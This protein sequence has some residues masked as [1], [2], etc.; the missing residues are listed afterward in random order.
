MSVIEEI[1]DLIKESK[2][3]RIINTKDIS[4]T[5]HTFGDIYFERMVLFSVLCQSYPDDSFITKKH[6]NNEEDPMFEGDFMAGI[7]TPNGVVTFHFKLEYLKYFDGVKEIEEGPKWDKVKPTES[8][9]RLL[10]LKK[11]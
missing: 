2:G 11:H 8:I 4:D 3:K 6:F 7:N 5:H 10:S 1:N 9:T